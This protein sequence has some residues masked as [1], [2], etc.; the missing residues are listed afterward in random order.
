MRTA[1][2]GV[3]LADVENGGESGDAGDVV[4][5]DA[6]GKIENTPLLQKASAP[7]HVDEGEIDEGEP[8]GKEQHVGLEGDAVGEGAGYERGGDD[9]EHH[10]VGNENEG[11]NGVIGRGRIEADAAQKSE[12]EVADDPVPVAAETERIAVEIPDHRGPAHGNE[13]LNHDGED[14]FAPDQAA[15][16]KGQAGGHQHDQAGA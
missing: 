15:V 5:D 12:V 7:N 2:G 13:T 4:D 9:G 6:A 16:E 8:S 10:L 14:V 11:G 1:I 3:A